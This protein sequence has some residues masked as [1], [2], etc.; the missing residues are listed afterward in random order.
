MNRKYKELEKVIEDL[1]LDVNRLR[2]TLGFM[3]ASLGASLEQPYAVISAK[4]KA[5][6]NVTLTELTQFVIDKKPIMRDVLTEVV[7]PSKEN[8]DKDGHGISN[9]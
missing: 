7:S 8:E 9:G 2:Y 4:T 6:G 5:A 3:A 1:Q